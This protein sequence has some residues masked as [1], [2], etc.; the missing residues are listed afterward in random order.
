[1][2]LKIW[3][4]NQSPFDK[5]P[6]RHDT[7][8]TLLH[9]VKVSLKT[10]LTFFFFYFLTKNTLLLIYSEPNHTSISPEFRLYSF[11]V[12]LHCV[13]CILKLELKQKEQT[14]KQSIKWIIG[15]FF[16]LLNSTEYVSNFLFS[17]WINPNTVK[18]LF[19]S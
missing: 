15:Q 18:N 5:P 17:N 4:T 8:G 2:L 13:T 7:H 14:N 1:M 9:S 16:F 3:K 11:I 10:K 6:F 19:F 12:Y